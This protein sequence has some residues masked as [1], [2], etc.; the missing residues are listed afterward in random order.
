MC[1]GF[2]KLSITLHRLGFTVL[3]F[4]GITFVLALKG[5]IK[6]KL[7]TVISPQKLNYFLN[8]P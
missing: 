2:F 4:A 3:C 7:K 8:R 1:S 5:N 6:F